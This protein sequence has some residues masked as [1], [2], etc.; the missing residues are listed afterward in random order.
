MKKI[1]ENEARNLNGG[2]KY[3]ETCPT[4]GKKFTYKWYEWFSYQ[5]AQDNAISD[6][7]ACKR[8]HTSRIV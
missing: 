4:C 1:S 2:F 8:S 5:I 7:L 6:M 3:T